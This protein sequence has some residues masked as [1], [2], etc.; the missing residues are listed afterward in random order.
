MKLFILIFIGV[1]TNCNEK[2][3]KESIDEISYGE[4]FQELSEHFCFPYAL[5]I[6]VIIQIV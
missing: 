2:N 4:I 6:I 3:V 5:T 1:F